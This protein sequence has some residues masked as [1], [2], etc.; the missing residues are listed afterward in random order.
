MRRIVFSL[1]LICSVLAL[2]SRSRSAL[3]SKSFENASM[4]VVAESLVTKRDVV[5]RRLMQTAMNDL[6]SSSV[7]K[8]SESAQVGDSWALSQLV[9]E[10]VVAQEAG[11]LAMADFNEKDFRSELQKLKANLSISSSISSE[12]RALEISDKE[13]ELMFKSMMVA[14]TFLKLKA[15]TSVVDISDNEAKLYFEKNRVKFASMPFEQFKETIKEYLAKE[16]TETRV[17]EWFEVLKRKYRV[18]FLKG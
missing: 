11:S 10:I 15:S 14:Q 18:R 9:L 6:K 2:S 3:R 1:L 4:A 5:A 7:T 16:A 13:L 17:K 12:W 8:G